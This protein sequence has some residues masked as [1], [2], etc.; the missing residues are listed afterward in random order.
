MIKQIL[1]FFF[2]PKCPFCSEILTGK[3]PFCKECEEKLTYTGENACDCCG[4]PIEEFAY[5]LCPDCRTDKKYFEKIF[6]PLVYK[7]PA[8]HAMV[9]FK[10]YSHPSYADAFALFLADKILKAAP[11]PLPFDFITFIPQSPKT[12]RSRGYNQSELIAK[13]LASLLRLP[14]R[15]MLIRTDDGVRQATLNAEER[16]KNVHKCYF[17][18]GTKADG[19]ALLVDDVY[20]TGAT[21]NHCSHLLIKSGCHKVYGAVMLIRSDIYEK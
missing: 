5:R 8:K 4:R 10:Y 18:S 13:K 12:R 16:R 14:V 11:D 15:D 1:D 7:D 9:Q 21:F 3:L 17:S 6:V 19:T 2:P 20:T